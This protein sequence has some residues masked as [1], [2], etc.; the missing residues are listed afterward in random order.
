[1]VNGKITNDNIKTLFTRYI[2]KGHRTLSNHIWKWKKKVNYECTRT[3]CSLVSS[4]RFSF[5]FQYIYQ[6]NIGYGRKL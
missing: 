1:M 6:R 3:F 5:K 4:H 2:L